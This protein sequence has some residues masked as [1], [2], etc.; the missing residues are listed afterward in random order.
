MLL[1]IDTSL[2]GYSACLFHK[3]E[4]VFDFVADTPQSQDLIP[5]LAKTF[6]EHN[7]ELCDITKILLS[8][9]PGS[10]TG[11][12]TVLSL[13]NTLKANID[14]EII[15]V[16]NFQLLRFLNPQAKKI[17]FKASPRNSSEF[18][19]SL[20]EDYENLQTNF[21]AQELDADIQVCD[22]YQEQSL[23]KL[24]VQYYQ[25]NF[26]LH[27]NNKLEAYYLREPSLRKAKK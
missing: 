20:D 9:G 11:I 13:V 19:V 17:A 23:A 14:A 1:A 6:S 24:L 15:A 2:K 5:E 16:N 7:L 18:Y 4:F 22:L 12:R 10:F 27:T 26:A 3:G 8:V 25:K 21:F